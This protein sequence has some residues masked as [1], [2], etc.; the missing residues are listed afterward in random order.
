MGNKKKSPVVVSATSGASVE[1][2]QSTGASY[3]KP[4]WPK[5]LGL[6]LKWKPT[7]NNSKRVDSDVAAKAAREVKP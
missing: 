6:P 1:A 5:Q 2:L 4:Q 3:S 7:I